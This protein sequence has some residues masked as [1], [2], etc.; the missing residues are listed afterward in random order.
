M[1]IVFSSDARFIHA[2][3]NT[4]RV[5][6]SWMMAGIRPFASNFK[7]SKALM[8]Q[9]LLHR[10]IQFQRI[11]REQVTQRRGSQLGSGLVSGWFDGYYMNV[12]FVAAFNGLP[13]DALASRSTSA[14]PPAVREILGR[15]PLSLVDF[16]Q[17][18]SPAAAECLEPLG[19]RSQALTRQRFGK[20]IRLFAPLYL[21][22]ECVNNCKYCGFSRDNPILRVTL[23][24][25]EV[26]REA[27]ALTEKGFRNL[28]LVAGEHPKFVSN[29][30]LAD[31]VRALHAGVPSISLEV[32][33]M[34]TDEYLPIVAGRRGGTGGVPGNLRPRDLRGNAHRRAEAEFRL[35][36][37]NAGTRLR[38][39]VSGGWASARCTAWATGG[40][41]RLPWRRTRNICCATAG[42]RS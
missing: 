42:R 33:P 31:C 12:S 6:C 29:G 15:T 32:G 25:E 13:L 7:L 26:V 9:T 21:S 14:E 41:R 2:I 36:A 16:A 34:E 28:L 37:G 17:L 3:I 11:H 18:L 22:N 40:A 23:S 19:R 30:Y 24:V 38:R 39:R 35:A 5:D 20:V 4:R 1:A 10:R 27:R 8:A